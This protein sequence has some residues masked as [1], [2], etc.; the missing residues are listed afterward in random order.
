MWKPSVTP[1]QVIMHSAK[2]SE[3]DEHKYVEVVDGK[4][5]YPDGYDNGR[6]VSDL[7]GTDA[8]KSS[9]D[10]AVKSMYSKDDSD[11]DD[12]NYNDNNRMGD[13]DFYGFKGKDGNYVI[14]EEDMKWTLPKGAKLDGALKKR[15]E[16]V[17]QEIE[18]RR[19]NGEKISADEW[20]KLVED[21]ING[22]TGDKK[23]K[24]GSKSSGKKSSKGSKS[25]SKAA[26]DKARKAKNKATMKART[27]EQQKNKQ[28]RMIKN[29]LAGKEYLNHSFWAP[30][31]DD[32]LMHH[33]VQ[34]QKWGVRRYQP[35]P[36]GYHGSGRYKGKKQSNRVQL[37][38]NQNGSKKGGNKPST[39]TVKKKKVS[40][41]SNREL[42]KYIDRMQ[43]EQRYNE[44]S[45]QQVSKGRQKVMSLVRDYAS[46]AGAVATTAAVVKTAYQIK[47]GKFGK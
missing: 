1:E 35:Y 28:K 36:D 14:L 45:S 25:S 4:Y 38:R 40:Q 6:T 22:E 13:T 3:W 42:Q 32:F 26:D 2:G 15:L 43:L 31:D 18:K 7:K 17:D 29:R 23:K 16:A 30:T 47:N 21:A 44:L 27:E 10:K 9:S 37:G 24:S 20:N 46:I 11:F 41:M 5:Y 12:K 8:N 34:G 39:T 33:G 19:Q